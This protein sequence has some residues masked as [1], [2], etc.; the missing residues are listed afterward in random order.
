MADA[1][2]DKDNDLSII[3]GLLESS[4]QEHYQKER[5]YSCEEGSSSD[6][7]DNTVDSSNKGCSLYL[8]NI[9]LDLNENGIRNLCKEY[10]DVT[11]I[12]TKHTPGEPTK[13]C[14]VDFQSIR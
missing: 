13:I 10:G 8:K 11:R 3:Y 6:T 14:F 1:V 9:S 2:A 5:R 7:N 4:M 12:H